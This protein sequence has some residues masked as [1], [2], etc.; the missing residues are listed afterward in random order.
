[1]RGR[2]DLQRDARCIRPRRARRSQ[3]R[4]RDLANPL[5]RR[6][7]FRRNRRIARISD[8]AEH[9]LVKARLRAGK[10]QIGRADPAKRRCRLGPTAVPG[11][12]KAR[13]ELLKAPPRK[14]GDQGA[15]IIEVTIGRGRRN[16]RK[17]GGFGEGESARAALSDERARRFDQRIAQIAVVVAATV[18]MAPVTDHGATIQNP[19]PG[20]EDRRQTGDLPAEIALLRS[21]IF[22]GTLLNV[23]AT[24]NR[25]MDTFAR[26]RAILIGSMGNLIEWYDVYAYSAF[27]LYFSGSFFKD[28]DL[29][30]QQ[31]FVALIFALGF[32]ARPLGGLLFGY[33][34]DRTGRR[35]SLLASVLL[36]CF[37][38]L[39][40]AVV[41]DVDTIGVAAP[42]ILT[43]A[44][45]LQGISQGGEYGSSATYLS[46]MSEPNRR[47]F[48]SGVWYM[49]LIGGQLC[50]IV[51]LL[52]LQKLFLSADQLRS[53]G[54]RIPFVIGALLS[55]L[56]LYMRRDMLETEHFREAK[57]RTSEM[58]SMRA[59]FAQWPR[60]LQVIGITVGGTCAFYTYTTYMQKF[61]KLSVK[62]TDDQTT[63]VT[64]G[65]LLFAILLQPLYGALS[66]RIGRKPLLVAFGAIGTL[67]T[68]PLLTILQQTKTPLAAFLIICLAWAIVSGYTSITAIVK[69][70]LFPTSIRALGVGLPYALTAAVFGGTT[71]S[72]ALYFKE[73]G[74]E[75]GFYFYA[76][77]LIFVSL[78]FYAFMPDTRFASRMDQA[79]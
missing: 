20:G 60:L 79:A 38:S 36:M 74:F 41:P 23:A 19:A 49:T 72:I 45:I 12:G 55:I 52:A 1:M 57:K 50:A 3:H 70:E 53:W 54:W 48:Y 63:A 71:D 29:A 76:S 28:K 46:E 5:E 13:S 11:G 24:V 6:F 32:V 58:G 56:A 2:P 27:A 42:L 62:L 43:M 47:G 18:N 22:G 14:F 67:G 77:G 21:P 73:S 44:R 15:A 51:V 34:A 68:Y 33:L 9:R 25:P 40:I 59:L 30:K 31:L 65:S 16:A 75:Q 26:V 64:A 37:G 4:R 8:V 7:G 61:L 69:A 35:N 39:M 66:D 10:I 78:M 17:L